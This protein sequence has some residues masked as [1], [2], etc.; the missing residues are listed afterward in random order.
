MRPPSRIPAKSSYIPA[1]EFT[2]TDAERKDQG[3]SWKR[4]DKAF[5]AAGAC[6]ILAFRFLERHPDGAYA[7]VYLR[8][9]N[10]DRGHHVYVTDGTWAFDFNGWTPERVLLAET[11]KACKGSDS[12]W[13]YELV[14]IDMDLE[15]FC[16]TYSHRPPGMFAYD[17]ISRAD[18]YLDSLN[19]D[20]KGRNSKP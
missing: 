7:I 6:H 8:P 4:N 14:D 13:S 18:A 9:S 11:A 10:S 19:Q 2:R 1:V 15:T 3:L 5:F 16:K 12:D 20:P 17:P